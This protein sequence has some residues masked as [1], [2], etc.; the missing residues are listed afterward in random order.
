LHTPVT[1]LDI[2]FTAARVFLITV[3]LIAGIPKF[4]AGEN[5]ANTLRAL[6]VQHGR[7]VLVLRIGVPIAET[8]LAVWLLIGSYPTAASFTA[9]AMLGSFTYVLVLLRARGAG[10]CACFMWDDSNVGVAHL[11]RNLVLVTVAIVIAIATLVGWYSWGPVWKLPTQSALLVAAS[12]LFVLL[13]YVLI[14]TSLQFAR[15]VVV[16][17]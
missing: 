17:P 4:V 9:V 15:N 3:F 12:V 16:D 5:M 14:A 2:V 7:T 8:G 10:G 11:V 13:V 1:P 6:G